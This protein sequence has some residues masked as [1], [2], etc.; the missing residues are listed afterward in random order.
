MILPT[1]YTVLMD[2]ENVT[3]IC[4]FRYALQCFI[5]RMGGF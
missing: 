1:E 2:G 3:S 4:D 5:N